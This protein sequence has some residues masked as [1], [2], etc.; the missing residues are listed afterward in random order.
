MIGHVPNYDWHVHHF[1]KA[2]IRLVVQ[3]ASCLAVI[4]VFAHFAKKEL[5]DGASGCAPLQA[6]WCPLHLQLAAIYLV[7]HGCFALVSPDCVAKHDLKPNLV[8]CLHATA[9]SS[10]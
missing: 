4:H 3:Y 7:P 6:R 9:P 2:V 1:D 10:T 8:R 5:S